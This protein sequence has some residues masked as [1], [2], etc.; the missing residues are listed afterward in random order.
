M[1]THSTNPV[2]TFSLNDNDWTGITLTA[3]AAKQIVTL[4]KNT[5]DSIGLCLSVKQSGCAG[6]GCLLYTS[7]A[8]DD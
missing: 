1:T 8:A 6:F 5:P 4:M 3:A 2:E 7:D